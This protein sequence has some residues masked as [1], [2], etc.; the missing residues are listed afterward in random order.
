MDTTRQKREAYQV[1][2]HLFKAHARLDMIIAQMDGHITNTAMARLNDANTDLEG[3]IEEL[4]GYCMQMFQKT[5]GELG[6][7]K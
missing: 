3:A 4:D 5:A 2:A 6:M 7:Y 1:Y